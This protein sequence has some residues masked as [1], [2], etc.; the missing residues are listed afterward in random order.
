M[1]AFVG[2]IVDGEGREVEDECT[3]A[4]LVAKA[5]LAIPPAAGGEGTDEEEE[6]EEDA[7]SVDPVLNLVYDCPPQTSEK[8]WAKPTVT[9]GALR[10]EVRELTR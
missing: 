10:D 3:L 8:F 5:A 1:G 7:A 2:R 9:H 6:D 4:S